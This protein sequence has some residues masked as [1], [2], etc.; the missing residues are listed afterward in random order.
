M[1]RQTSI[2]IWAMLFCG[3]AAGQPPRD[4][5]LLF[6]GD[7]LLSRQVA[8]ELEFRKASPWAGFQELFQSA[9]WVGGNFEGTLGLQL[10][11]MA[12]AQPCFAT[13]VSAVELL[14]KSG[15]AAVTVENNHAGDLG[16]PGRERTLLRFREA[17]LLALDFAQS[18]QFLKFGGITVAVVAITTVRAADGRVQEIPSVEVAQKLRLA[19]L[20]ANLVVVSIHWGNELQDWS[21]DVQREQARWLVKHGAGLIVGHHPHVVQQAECVEGAPVFYSLGNHVFDQKYPETKDGLIA[22]CRISGGKLACGGIATRTP[23][24][25]FIP[26]ILGVHAETS[27]ALGSCT[28]KL[29]D[30]LVLHGFHIRPVPWD[31]EQSTDGLTLTGWREGQLAWQ[32]RRQHALSLQLAPFLGADNSPLLF[33]LERHFSPIDREDGVRPYVY[34]VGPH[35]LIA[36]WRGSALAWPLLDAVVDG[37]GTLC[38]LHRGDS[39]AVLNPRTKETRVEA[40]RWKGFGFAGVS[41]PGAA[42][43]CREVLQ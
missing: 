23:P 15:F 25:T 28:A 7:I 31:A 43:N 4:I 10:D 12:H 35:G 17:G 20:L 13:P 11:C 32:S 39:F 40:Y 6:T 1:S 19:R 26:A 27:A 38:A 29:N 41:S 34:D 16:Q 33:S 14:K 21:S 24:G 18:P 5:R 42:D 9:D 36:K 2:L 30:D 22:D 37:S 8:A 3:A